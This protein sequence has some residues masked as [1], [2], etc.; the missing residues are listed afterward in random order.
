MQVLQ[1]AT[2]MVQAGGGVKVVVRGPRMRRVEAAVV[3]DMVLR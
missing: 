2:A 3:G 1:L